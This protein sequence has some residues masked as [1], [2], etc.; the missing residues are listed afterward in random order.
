MSAP[1]EQLPRV[2]V[3]GSGLLGTSVGLALREHGVEVIL[4]DSDE[5]AVRL[6]AELGAGVAGQPAG[7]TGPADLAVLAVPPA[8]VARVLLESQ[9]REL[10]RVYTDVASVKSTVVDA[11][12]AYGCDLSSFV[13]GHPMAGRERSGPAAARGDLFLGRPWVLCPTGGSSDT[14]RTTV[15]ALARA[16]GAEPSELDAGDHDRAVAAVSHAPHLVAAVMAAQ[17]TEADEVALELAGQGLR[18]ATRIAG[19]DPLLWAEILDANAPA[20]AGVID[21]VAADLT[22]AAAALRAPAAD[23]PGSD[24]PVTDREALIE[25]L[26]RGVAGRARVPGK[27]GGPAPS[28]A[29]VAV[30]V[31]DQPGELGRLLGVVGEIGVNVEDVAL[32]HSPGLPVGVIELSVRPDAADVLAEQLRQRGWSVHR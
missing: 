9:Q 11:A 21:G 27:R 28:Y 22:A 24:G 4:F 14:A 3:V 8:A 29:A 12:R 32:E 10:A 18:D 2:A 15:L 7:T 25:L 19:G 1:R 20:V 13:A 23:H 6:A 30:V 26:R 31:R 16:C 17:L 5:G